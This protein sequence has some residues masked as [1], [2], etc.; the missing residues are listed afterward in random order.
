MYFKPTFL[1]ILALTYSLNAQTSESAIAAQIIDKTLNSFFAEEK[2]YTWGEKAEHIQIIQ[3]SK[4]MVFTRDPS[5]AHFLLVSK[6]VPN[7]IANNSVILTTEYNMLNKDNRVVGAFFW[8]KGRPNL[9]F[10][11]NRLEKANLKLSRE[12]DK[13]IEDDL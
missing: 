8:Q 9:L 6:T 13:F 12:F 1:W 10:L 3:Q 2:I 7:D 5:Q 11:R 4:R